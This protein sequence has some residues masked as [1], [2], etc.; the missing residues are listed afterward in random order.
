MKVFV[1]APRG[2]DRQ[3]V[4][5]AGEGGFDAQISPNAEGMRLALADDASAAGVLCIENHNIATITLREWRAAG[6]KNLLF[7]I[8]ELDSHPGAAAVERVECLVAG[9][10][11][12]QAHPINHLEFV[13]RLAALARR[14]RDYAPRHTE[15]PNGVVF[16]PERGVVQHPGGTVMLSKIEAKVL[17]LLTMRPEQVITKE[18]MM[19]WLYQGRDEP[20][21]KIVDVFVCKIRKRLSAALGGIDVIETVWGR[22]FRFLPA[23]FEPTLTEART[24][25]VRK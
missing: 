1:I 22:G 12:A 21:F 20:D 25:V 11:D 6:L 19:N 3:L 2:V 9:A 23:G 14:V 15:M 24:A 17:D 7:V 18:M 5:V 8:S 13:S 10:D 16:F 4:R